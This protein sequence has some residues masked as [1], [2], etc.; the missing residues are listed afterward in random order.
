MREWF[1]FMSVFSSLFTHRFTYAAGLIDFVRGAGDEAN[2]FVYSVLAIVAVGII[3]I[4]GN[5]ILMMF[6][7]SKIAKLVEHGA[8]IAAMGIFMGMAMTMFHKFVG[9]IFG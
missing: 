9:L 7:K 6:G 5:T 1:I 8:Y 4:I 2:S 3:G